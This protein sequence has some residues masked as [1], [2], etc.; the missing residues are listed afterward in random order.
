MEVILA[1]LAASLLAVV[2]AAAQSLSPDSSQLAAPGQ[3]RLDL[4][5]VEGLRR[6]PQRVAEQLTSLAR[7]EVLTLDG[8]RRVE[9]QLSDWP[10][11]TSTA[12]AYVPK[13]GGLVDLRLTVSERDLVPRRPI[14]LAMIGARAV[15]TREVR[16]A[17]GPMTSGG[18]RVELGWRF[19]PDR[20][21]Y[22]AGLLVPAPWGGLW[23]VQASSE[24][25]PL[26]APALATF[27]HDSAGVVFS[28]WQTGRLRWQVGGGIDR[29]AD[30][31]RFG[32]VQAAVDLATLGDGLRLRARGQSWYGDDGFGAVDVSLRGTRAIRAGRYLLEA[33]AAISRVSAEA[34]YDIWPAGDTG[35]ARPTTL[36]RAH[37]LLSRGRYRSSR[38]GADVATTSV[39]AQR[40]WRRGG[41]QFGPAVLADFGRTA[42]RLT[43][44][45]LRDVDVG[46]GF[47]ARFPG[48]PGTIRIDA[49]NGLRDGHKALSFVYEP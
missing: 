13:P 3:R 5:Q 27:R 42:R 20:P 32:T 23:G 29:W 38:L 6:T 17:L 1:L 45:S 28:A 33:R 21:R 35:H 12:V 37:P 24:R 36:L 18:D 16:V 47:R 39:E 19:W 14:T 4:I 25:Q 15:V 31:G 30:R 48:M 40:L 9:R 26:T 10:A 46:I 8:L 11:M 44:G 7:G 41:A 2:P 43:E 34:P 22:S 49:A